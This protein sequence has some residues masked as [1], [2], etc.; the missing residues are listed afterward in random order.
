MSDIRHR[1]ASRLIGMLPPAP[2]AGCR[3]RRSCRVP[4]AE[5]DTIVA[6]AE[7][8]A[9]FRAGRRRRPRDVLCGREGIEPSPPAPRGAPSPRLRATSFRLL[10]ER[11]PLPPGACRPEPRR[12]HLDRP[13]G[14]SRSRASGRWAA[15]PARA[16]AS[17]S[18][19]AA[20][21]PT[22]RSSAG[23]TGAVAIT[24]RRGR[25]ARVADDDTEGD[26]CGH[27]TAC[28]G[29]V[30][31]ARARV[32][33]PQR[34]RA[35]RRLH[36]QRPGAARRACAGRSSR[37]STS[38]NMSLSTTKTPVRRACCTSSPTAPTSAARCSSPRRTT[39]RSRATRGA[40]R[41]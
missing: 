14:R 18:S 19:T 34:P 37:A 38:I 29:I 9:A 31:V 3:R 41:R 12:Q 39:C 8:D 40:S 6:R 23:S 2:A 32:R 36:G 27:G 17:A 24:R 13:T 5:L 28:A 15:R 26:V 16:S 7:A 33:A 4:A 20:S 25:R 35:R 10:G 30:R 21:R 1:T 11:A 22:I